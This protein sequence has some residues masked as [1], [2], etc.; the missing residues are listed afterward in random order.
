MSSGILEATYTHSKNLALFVFIYKSLTSLMASM[1][2]KPQQYHS[3]LSAFIGG[4][5][6]FGKY[7]K[8]N[9]Q[10][11]YTLIVDATFNLKNL[12]HLFFKTDLEHQLEPNLYI[13]KG[14]NT[15]QGTITVKRKIFALSY[16]RPVVKN[17][18]FD[19]F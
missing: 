17:C 14:I 4:Y 3:F 9:E 16:F 7:N 15:A 12:F 1:E 18:L 11:S 5:F 13:L 8:I 10:V 2:S 19:Q 6:V